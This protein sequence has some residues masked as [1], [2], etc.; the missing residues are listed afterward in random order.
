MKEPTPFSNVATFIILVLAGWGLGRLQTANRAK[1]NSDPWSALVH[2]TVDPVSGGFTSIANS[3]SDFFSGVLNAKKLSE[4]NRELKANSAL[5]ESYLETL[6]QYESEIANL[7]KIQNL[8]SDPTQKIVADII[9]YQTNLNLVTLNKGSQDD[10]KPGSAVMT[11]AGLLGRVQ[12]VDNHTATVLLVTSPTLKLGAMVQ[13][14]PPFAGIIRGEN[15]NSLLLDLA[16][17]TAPVQVGDKIVTSG[18]DKIK[19][20]IPIGVVTKVDSNQE[21]G[22]LQVKVFPN[23]NVT[24]SREVFVLK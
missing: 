21:F 17:P 22:Q 4:E 14:T 6:K 12:S 15:A 1:G 8:P 23:V 3:S 18:F 16:D 7:R 10:V 9:G 2:T 11:A 19:R 24:A 13:R 5:V 20:N